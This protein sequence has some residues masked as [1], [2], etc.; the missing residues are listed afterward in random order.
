LRTSDPQWN[1]HTHTH[2]HITHTHTHTHTH[3][4]THTHT[5][6]APMHID[7][8]LCRHARM[9]TR[10]RTDTPYV[11]YTYIFMPIVALC[12]L[13]LNVLGQRLSQFLALRNLQYMPLCHVSLSSPS[14]HASPPSTASLLVHCVSFE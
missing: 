4:Q 1:T 7:T 11:L 6:Y 10:A 5:H 8:H 9:H 12:A 14:H 3:T 2:T 13:V